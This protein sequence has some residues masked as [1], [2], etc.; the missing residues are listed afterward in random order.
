PGRRGR[1]QRRPRLRRALGGAG[2]GRPGGRGTAHGVRR[3]H[4]RVG[5]G[6]P[7]RLG[8]AGHRR[9][10]RPRL[11]HPPGR[12]PPSGDPAHD[13]PT[14]PARGA[15]T[16][17]RDRRRPSGVP[18][19]S[20]DLDARRQAILAAWRDSPTRFREDAN[21]EEDLVLGAYADRLLVEL[22]QNAADA[23]ARAGVPGRVRVTVADGVLSVANTGAPLDPAGVDGLTSLR[24]SAKRAEDGGESVGRLG[25]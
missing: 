13:F 3:R 15:T 23:A 12:A 7:V 18:P 16:E 5:A 21:A 10:L 24:A 6:A 25:A 19:V 22:L 8:R 20:F 2:R 14:C 11:T 4:R 1:G 17:T 9:A